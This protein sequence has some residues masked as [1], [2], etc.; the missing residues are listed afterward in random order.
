MAILFVGGERESLITASSSV[1][2]STQ[3]GTFDTNYCRCSMALGIAQSQ[4]YVATP[5][6]ASNETDVW[7]H[8]EYIIDGSL[9]ATGT[10]AHPW[11][12]FH[13]ALAEVVFRFNVTGHSTSTGLTTIQAQYYNGSAWVDTGASFTVGRAA[14][15]RW[16]AHVVC[17]GASQSTCD[18]YLNGVL[19][20]S[21]SWTN[22]YATGIQHVRIGKQSYSLTVTSYVS[23]VIFAT[24]DTRSMR[25][26]TIAPT[27]AG[28]YS[29]GTGTYSDIAETVLNDSNGWT[30]ATAD[31]KFSWNF[32]DLSQT[33]AIK[34]VVLSSRVSR[35]DTG[36]QA[37]RG[38]MR[39]GA[40]VETFFSPYTLSTALECKQTIMATNPETGSAWGVASAVND[41]EFGFQSRA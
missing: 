6:L 33:M 31:Q 15:M 32:A 13:R 39:S 35:S 18:L 37:M 30:S 11:L 17:G 22:A 27:G 14:I 24:E 41:L 38:F 16:D 10:A 20:S 36:P 19:H 29:E 7:I 26:A 23:Q 3:T 4:D 8:F 34:A 2:E 28:T 12:M 40:G 9:Q 25:L 1:V 5:N 21:Y